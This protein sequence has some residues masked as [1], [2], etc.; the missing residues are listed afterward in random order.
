MDN[1]VFITP[2]EPEDNQGPIKLGPLQRMRVPA[3]ELTERA[4]LAMRLYEKHVGDPK[5][6]MQS[7]EIAY[8]SIEMAKDFFDQLEK[9]N[10]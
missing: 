4:K 5:Y 2:G 1:D 6:G 8:W 9:G 7:P 3:P 10:E